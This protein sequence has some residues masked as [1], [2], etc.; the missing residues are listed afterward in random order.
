MRAILY[1]HKV[2]ALDAEPQ[3]ARADGAFAARSAPAGLEPATVV[4]PDDYLARLAK[5][6]PA[7]SL[8]VL[9]LFTG[10]L[11]NHALGW[12][13]AALVFP[14]IM[15]LALDR[16]RRGKIRPDLRP[17]GAIYDVF[18][19]V[20]YLGWA[21]GTTGLARGLVSIDQAE[22]SF[23]VLVVA[24]GL[25]WFDDRLGARFERKPRLSRRSSAHRPPRR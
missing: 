25:G 15:A 6:V 16:D 12:R 8:A 2:R 4:A 21:L 24:F 19:I 3:P 7:E 1:P 13:I 17:E 5:H 9:L 23:I 14:G 18:V 22:A 11:E 10:Q 20:A